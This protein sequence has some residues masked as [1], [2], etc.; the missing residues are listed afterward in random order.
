MGNHGYRRREFVKTAGMG[1]VSFALAPAL[2]EDAQAK[3][4][5]RQP[6][7][8]FFFPDQLR[9][10]YVEPA[11]EAPVRTPNLRRLAAEGVRF[12]SAVTPA[13]V[14]APAR[15][16]I[17]S[18]KEYDRC[19]VAANSVSYPLDQ[20][21]LYSLLRS[22]G[23]HVMG[24][25]KFDLHK[26]ELDWGVDGKRLIKE[27]G[28]SDGIDNGGKHDAVNAYK[29]V[30]KPMDPYFA[31][32]QELGLAQV[33]VADFEKRRGRAAAFPTP[34]PDEAYCDNWIAQ[35]GLSLLQRAPAQKPW[36]L[37]VNFNGPHEPWDITASMEKRWR[38]VRFPQPNKGDEFT[39]E[40]YNAVRQNY[41]AMIENIDRWIAVFVEKLKER[42]DLDHTLIVFSSDHGE[43]LGDHNSW[44]KSKPYQPSAGVPLV[45]WGMGTRRG[46]VGAFP[47]TTLDL[48]ATFL[49]YAGLAVPADMDSRSLR[50]YLEGK[51]DKHRDHVLSG[52]GSWRMV[53]Q[54]GYKYIRGYESGALLFDLAD[55]P[56][57]N[58]NLAGTMPAVVERLGRIL[59]GET[60]KTDLAKSGNRTSGL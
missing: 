32:L 56:L 24:C 26:P 59:D 18:G 39:P 19:R 54:G 5:G 12:T 23:Y 10:D 1:V 47:A 48:T 29:R 13:P 53:I 50:P 57:E 14:C 8:L 46:L 43:M 16:C 15:A 30:G 28:F 6:N 7:I 58:K 35:N 17:S 4:A 40:Q 33:H 44:G 38:G 51:V 3:E 2:A 11:P 41:A 36:F 42:G 21:T 9:H 27:W 60:G 31:Y 37:Q 52:L 55:D 45:I 22:S 34:L 20:L 25:G 49:D